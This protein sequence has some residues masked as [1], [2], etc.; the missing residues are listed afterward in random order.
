MPSPHP[1]AGDEPSSVAAVGAVTLAIAVVAASG[2]Y[3]PPRA[4]AH[5]PARAVAAIGQ[6]AV[7][8]PRAPVGGQRPTTTRS[9]AVA[10]EA[11]PATPVVRSATPTLTPGASPS[12]PAT[13]APAGPV[14]EVVDAPPPFFRFRR[15]FDAS[16]EV[17]ASRYY[18]YG[19]DAGGQYLLHHGAD[20]GNAL[21][22]PVLAVGDGEVVHAG[23][24]LDEP[25]G[26]MTDFYGNLVVVR[27]AETVDGEPLF[28]LYGHLSR[29]S[30]AAGDEVQA[31]DEVGR[32]GAAGI[33]L[34]PH[35]HLE[36][37]TRAQD[38]EATLNPELF[39]APLAGH[40]T[41]VGRVEDAAGEPVPGVGVALYQLAEGGSESW[42]AETTSYPGEHVNGAPGWR[43]GFL[44]ADTPAG[45]YSVAATVGGVR[46]SAPVTVTSGEALLVQLRP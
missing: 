30:V 5:R 45:R 29:L 8:T 18:P 33:A 22:T 14:V 31:G 4:P 46:V 35:L 1:S 34:G 32:V 16:H 7:A 19:T 27:H 40:G 44:F 20:I 28:S 42:L 6:P 37:R 2:L 13:E 21:D 26:P 36:F 38:Y 11:E 3:R 25:W 17:R 41:I 15:P 39:L 43:E 12:P 24:D 10:P 9:T 23:D